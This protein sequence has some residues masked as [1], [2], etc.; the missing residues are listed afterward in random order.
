MIEPARSEA[1]KDDLVRITTDGRRLI[2]VGRCSETPEGL[3]LQ[4]VRVFIDPP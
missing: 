3:L 2:A 1:R 4:P